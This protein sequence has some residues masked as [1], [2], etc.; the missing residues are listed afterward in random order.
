MDAED[1]VMEDEEAQVEKD[2]GPGKAAEVTESSGEGLDEDRD[3]T[4][5]GKKDRE[6]GKVPHL[7]LTTFTT[8]VDA[9]NIQP[10]ADEAMNLD[11]DHSLDIDSPIP[12]PSP[13]PA[14]Q[15]RIKRVRSTASSQQSTDFEFDP[16]YATPT[17]PEKAR[18][19]HDAPFNDTEPEVDRLL[20][21]EYNYT[22]NYP[23]LTST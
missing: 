6:G 10:G 17:P 23:V 5:E 14:Q 11:D 7:D 4:S 3:V 9:L 20:K 2:V 8:Q 22:P 15:P 13:P 18:R 21:R 16:E 1:F 19:T 12:T